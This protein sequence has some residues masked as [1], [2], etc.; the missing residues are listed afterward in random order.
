[1]YNELIYGDFI[2][3]QMQLEISNY[4][5]RVFDDIT[6]CPN[7][8]TSLI[9]AVLDELQ[10]REDASVR[11][12]IEN[13]IVD[14]KKIT[15]EQRCLMLVKLASPRIKQTIIKNG[16]WEPIYAYKVLAGRLSAHRNTN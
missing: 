16:Y 2:P 8:Y 7:L 14:D 4:L 15:K 11:R 3:V 6:Y 12:G 1:M 9:Q 10:G 5:M 13:N